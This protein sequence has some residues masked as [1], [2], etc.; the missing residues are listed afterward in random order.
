MK[1]YPWA[2]IH[3]HTP[4][5][6]HGSPVLTVFPLSLDQL[7]GST[8]WL[9]SAYQ[10]YSG[11]R[12]NNLWCTGGQTEK[13]NGLFQWHILWITQTAFCWRMSDRGDVPEWCTDGS[14]TKQICFWRHGLQASGESKGSVLH[15][16][17]P[18]FLVFLGHIG[19]SHTWTKNKSP[20]NAEALWCTWDFK[21]FPS[22]QKLK[23]GTTLQSKEPLS[24]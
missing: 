3:L 5:L 13:S 16:T 23:G 2:Q 22:S 10:L 9:N 17:P 15:L 7:L 4:Q 6:P 20:I 21:V 14:S 1:T 18:K 11:G 8:V 19:H 12:I 24:P